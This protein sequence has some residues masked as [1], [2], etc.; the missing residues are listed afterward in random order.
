MENV[1]RKWNASDDLRMARNCFLLSFAVF[2]VVSLVQPCNVSIVMSAINLVICVLFEILV[3]VDSRKNE[4]SS[5][6]SV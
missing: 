4:N 3:K 5:H 6:S 1:K 2:T